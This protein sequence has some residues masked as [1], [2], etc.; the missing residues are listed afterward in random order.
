MTPKI[1]FAIFLLAFTFSSLLYNV[2]GNHT[3]GIL[4]LF[5]TFATGA[6]GFVLLWRTAEEQVPEE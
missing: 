5:I 3:F 1:L 2:L 6:T 4:P